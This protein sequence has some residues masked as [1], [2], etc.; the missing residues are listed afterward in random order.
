VRGISLLVLFITCFS[1]PA[2]GADQPIITKQTTL[3]GQWQPT[4]KDTTNALEAA[5]TLVR[6]TAEQPEGSS[7]PMKYKFDAAR[8]ISNDFSR[9]AVQFIGKIDHGK[10]I[11]VCNFFPVAGIESEFK[12]WKTS[13]V[14]VMDG[15]SSFWN[16]EYDSQT[17]MC[18]N[19]QINGEA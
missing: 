3:H 4:S 7:W 2:I 9:Y 18:R 8:K 14:A 19:L 17:G 12:Y 11:I 6:K 1:L 13:Q 10:K 5:I 15:G 16:I